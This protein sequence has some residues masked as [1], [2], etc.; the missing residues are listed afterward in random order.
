MGKVEKKIPTLVDLILKNG[1]I[2]VNVKG[3]DDWTPL[4]LA[5][6]DENNKNI[7]HN[8]QMLLKENIDVNGK[9]FN[10]W[11]P[12]AYAI[13]LSY[14]SEKKKE[15]TYLKIVE[16]LL[17]SRGI[18]VNA[19]IEGNWTPLML[20]AS[21]DSDLLVDMLLKKGA[22]K[23]IVNDSGDIAYDLTTNPKIAKKLYTVQDVEVVAKEHI[24]DNKL[25]LDELE[26]VHKKYRD[27]ADRLEKFTSKSTDLKEILEEVVKNKNRLED[28]SN[29]FDVDSQTGGKIRACSQGQAFKGG[30]P[31]LGRALISF[32]KYDRK[33]LN[34]LAIKWKINPV[35]YKYKRDLIVALKLLM[36]AKS[37]NI[38]TRNGLNQIAGICRINIKGRMLNDKQLYKK[39]MSK[40]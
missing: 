32:S 21:K 38:K 2:N 35:M 20:A 3:N 11:T 19:T 27:V 30:R 16:E 1:G 9:G 37:G 4:M 18:N 39:I 17:K 6:S 29:K 7:L 13:E 25:L 24:K 22:R 12:L 15:K 31:A 5:I 33:S 40:I 10:D 23:N 36:Y 34:H 8:V 26:I 14:D 28:I